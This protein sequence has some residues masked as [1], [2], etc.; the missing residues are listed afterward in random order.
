MKSKQHFNLSKQRGDASLVV[1]LIV[2][3]SLIVL[4][5]AIS[6]KRL[7]LQEAQ[8]LEQR[9]LQLGGTPVQKIFNLDNGVKAILCKKDDAVYEKF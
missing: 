8:E 6:Q 4:F 7:T 5:S 1:L 2:D 9:C 3:I